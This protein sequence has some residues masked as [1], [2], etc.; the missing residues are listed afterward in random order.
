MVEQGREEVVESSRF[1]KAYDT[2]AG[3]FKGSKVFNWVKGKDINIK[4]KT[5]AR[6]DIIDTSISKS[7]MIRID[8]PHANLPTP[9]ININPEITGVPDPHIPLP[10]GGPAVSFI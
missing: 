4:W 6:I 5:D 10:A 8:R 7:P 9:H 3:F 1:K 2:T